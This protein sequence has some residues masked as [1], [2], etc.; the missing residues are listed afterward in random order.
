[1]KPISDFLENPVPYLQ[2]A[3]EAAT[4]IVSLQRELVT[5]KAEQTA[6]HQA[7]RI[8]WGSAAAAC[9][10]FALFFA[11]GWLGIALHERGMSSFWLAGAYF[12][13]F[14]LLTTIFGTIALRRKPHPN[15][16]A[17]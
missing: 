1:M 9:G 2:E 11:F 17:S 16:G 14:G 15:G 10:F 5:L 13:F 6:V 3:Q 4:R 12:V 7:K 8:A